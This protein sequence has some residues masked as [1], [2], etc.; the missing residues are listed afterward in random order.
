MPHTQSFYEP[1]VKKTEGGKLN[2][3][4]KITINYSQFTKP[5]E[6][7]KPTIFFVSS[8]SDIFHKGVSFEAIDNIFDVMS[9]CPHHTFKVLT[10][11][12]ERMYDWFAWKQE[13]NGHKYDQWPLPNVQL[14]VSVENQ[15]YADERIPF[16]QKCPA[17]A[18]FLSCE[19]LLGPVNLYKHDK[20][21]GIHQVIVGGES[22]HEA[23]PMHP[24]WVSMIHSH[25]IEANT[26]FW[27][28]QWGEWMPSDGATSG[29]KLIMLSYMGAII[30]DPLD[31][32][33]QMAQIM[34]K[35]GAKA[36]GDLLYGK[37]YHEQPIVE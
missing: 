21:K 37:Q 29:K 16:L 18:K 34:I 28:K 15:K 23:R 7:K 35:V 27:F 33:V 3:T 4:G 32:K 6:E 8:M 13:G 26:A 5:L 10:K 17:K 14:G 1:S 20:L 30:Q 24:E 19:P 9:K 12:A 11:R 25:C 31:C 36:A 22:G 2:W